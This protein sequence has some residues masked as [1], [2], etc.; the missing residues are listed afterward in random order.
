MDKKREITPE[1]VGQRI[2]MGKDAEDKLIDVKRALE[3]ALITT[4]KGG[5]GELV[6]S[7]RPHEANVVEATQSMPDGSEDLPIGNSTVLEKVDRAV[8]SLG[9]GVFEALN[10]GKN[11]GASV[12]EKGKS[13]FGGRKAAIGTGIGI[14]A[15]VGSNVVPSPAVAAEVNEWVAGS[16]DS[17]ALVQEGIGEDSATP[18]VVVNFDDNEGRVTA[19]VD[20]D[21]SNDGVVEVA[22]EQTPE[23]VEAVETPSTEI[24]GSADTRTEDSDSRVEFVVIDNSNET[25]LSNDAQPVV[26]VHFGDGNSSEEVPVKEETVAENLPVNQ[27]E[28][29]VELTP[30]EASVSTSETDSENV[31]E[32]STVEVLPTTE[33]P[34]AEATEPPTNQDTPIE[35]APESSQPEPKPEPE[36]GPEPEP[37]Q[38]L[39]AS[40][41]VETVTPQTGN[42]L[43]TGVENEETSIITVERG[44]TLSGLAKEHGTTVAELIRLNSGN[45]PSLVD[46]PNLIHVGDKLVVSETGEFIVIVKKNQ[47]LSEIARGTDYTAEELAELNSIE[48]PDIILVNQIIKIPGQDETIVVQEGQTVNEL[49]ITYDVTPDE[50]VKAND[51][52]DRDLILDGQTLTIPAGQPEVLKEAI[53]PE[54]STPEEASTLSSEA[55]EELSSFKQLLERGPMLDSV[56][57]FA[58]YKWDKNGD[59]SL[60]EP[61]LN[62]MWNDWSRAELA[63]VLLELGVAGW[64]DYDEGVEVVLNDIVETDGFSLRYGNDGD[65]FD[66]NDPIDMNRNMMRTL[67]IAAV[68]LPKGKLYIANLTDGGHIGDSNHFTD[69]RDGEKKYGLGNAVDIGNSTQVEWLNLIGDGLVLNQNTIGGFREFIL[70]HPDFN[71]QMNHGH[72]YTPSAGVTAGHSGNN[73][74]A[75]VSFMEVITDDPEAS[76]V[77]DTASETMTEEP[78]SDEPRKEAIA[79][80]DTSSETSGEN[81]SAEDVVVEETPESSAASSSDGITSEDDVA[82]DED[83]V[84]N[85]EVT[86]QSAEAEEEHR[87]VDAGTT[88]ESVKPPGITTEQLVVEKAD[89]VEKLVALGYTSLA[90]IPKA[91]QKKFNKVL[92]QMPTIEEAIDKYNARQGDPR[93]PTVPATAVLA[94]AYDLGMRGDDLID[95]VT[96]ARGES[97]GF[98]PYVVGDDKGE[99]TSD[100]RLTRLAV[101]I[102]QFFQSNKNG[103]TDAQMRRAEV[104]LHPVAAM[105]EMVDYKNSGGLTPWYFH[106][107][108]KEHPNIWNAH[109][110][111]VLIAVEELEDSGFDIIP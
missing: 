35:V 24:T 73:L 79:T 106:S 34:V 95:S 25:N 50:I 5:G 15:V 45:Y 105:I 86:T 40:G 70:G 16:D 76:V 78:V 98:H 100:N 29:P 102:A 67:A 57:E 103:L 1:S 65:D 21:Q 62:E 47:T 89:T 91:D 22:E 56:K 20:Q 77:L 4:S 111:K 58:E 104:L 81:N 43:E 49:A 61:L 23:P 46:N 51:L 31:T 26:T 36:P 82:N 52:V 3:L 83:K 88:A 69:R 68:L 55:V 28:T 80:E 42:E 33:A 66:E 97:I 9:E 30:E 64:I 85:E 53:A 84:A 48:N 94:I 90:K 17:S 108:E 27:V 109:K 110:D 74:H 7:F 60:D 39:P 107:N 75:H 18:Q 37:E 6:F 13:I 71:N 2:D 63:Q 10:A 92:A 93:G 44:Q 54:I 32:D 96:T 38:T 99:R 12:L 59:G 72:R 41:G 14:A 11:A 101:G 87:A 8:V 19:F